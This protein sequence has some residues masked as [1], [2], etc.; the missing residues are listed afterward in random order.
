MYFGLSFAPMKNIFTAFTLLIFVFGSSVIA[1]TAGNPDT[2]DVAA[3]IKRYADSKKKITVTP[4]SGEQV[5]G[6]VSA[7]DQDKFTVTDSKS[8]SSSTFRYADVR[9][10]RK[11]NSFTSGGIIAI[12]A[13][14]AAAAVVIGLVGV[15]CRNEGGC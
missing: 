12:V 10:V 11:T 4:I 5:K 13:A 9:R 14:G 1:Q 3:K 2:A 8:G 7:F 6:Y 15:R